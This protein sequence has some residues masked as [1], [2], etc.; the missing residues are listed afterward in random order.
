MTYEVAIKWAYCWIAAL[1][2]FSFVGITI[3]LPL[4]PMPWPLLL[5]AGAGAWVAAPLV[6][7]ALTRS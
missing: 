6:W 1:A 5:G 7:A 3:R 4:P 2:A